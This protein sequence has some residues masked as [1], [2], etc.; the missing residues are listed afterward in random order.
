MCLRRTELRSIFQSRFRWKLTIKIRGSRRIT[1]TCKALFIILD[2]VR[3]RDITLP[4]QFVMWIT[5]T[6]SRERSGSAL[7]MV[8]PRKRALK[9]LF[10]TKISKAL[11]TCYYIPPNEH[12]VGGSITYVTVELVQMA[13]ILAI[14]MFLVTA[15]R[16]CDSRCV[17]WSKKGF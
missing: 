1:T 11:H 13:R 12:S 16:W 7:T 6:Q 3:H 17:G 14:A 15:I 5:I 9:E 10:Q 4:T 2:L 8:I